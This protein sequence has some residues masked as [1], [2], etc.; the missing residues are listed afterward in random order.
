MTEDKGRWGPGR[1]PTEDECVE[2][3]RTAGCAP[4]VIE[5]TQLVKKVALAI[6]SRIAENGTKVDVE[7]V[8]AGSILHDI[9]RGKDHGIRH[10]IVGAE[11]GKQ[12]GLPRELINIIERH[13]GAGIS[14]ED[15]GKIGLPP[16]DFIPL[17]IEEKI[18]AHADNLVGD[19]T[20]IPLSKLLNTFD[21]R[22]LSGAIP[23]MKAL[24]EELSRLAGLDL[25]QL[26][27][28]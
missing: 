19:K 12:L 22:G 7:L 5:H 13:I 8:R 17:T 16:R 27:V 3:M 23:R 18:V 9:G 6:A 26:D 1:W 14:W 21:R 4:H 20:K 25:D 15:A 10:A 11:T 28:N 24:H 2:L